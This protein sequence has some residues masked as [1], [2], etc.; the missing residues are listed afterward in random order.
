MRRRRLT[1]K[2]CRAINGLCLRCGAVPARAGL[3]QCAPCGAE[4]ARKSRAYFREVIIPFREA[5]LD[6]YG[7]RCACCGEAQVVF[8]TVDHVNNDG[9]EHRK[10][11]HA[12]GIY[13]WLL[14][15]GFPPGFQILCFNCNCGKQRNGGTCPHQ[16]QNQDQR[17]IQDQG[18]N[19]Q[20]DQR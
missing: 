13:R 7:R 3:T 14:R 11:V 9:A 8:L 6:H 5:V 15:R 10:T 1:A 18:Q 4:G 12:S 2:Q 20:E 16:N 17:Q 19:H